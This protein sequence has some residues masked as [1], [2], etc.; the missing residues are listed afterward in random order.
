MVKRQQ[1]HEDA[2]LFGFERG[3]GGGIHPSTTVVEISKSWGICSEKH[4][5]RSLSSQME[6]VHLVASWLPRS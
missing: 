6:T 3:L 1:S 2:I 5:L 4:P